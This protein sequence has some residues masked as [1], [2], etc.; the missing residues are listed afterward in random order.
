MGQN[1]FF[2]SILKSFKAQ[3]FFSVCVHIYLTRLKGK[4]KLSFCFSFFF[5]IDISIN[6]KGRF[7]FLLYCQNILIVFYFIGQSYCKVSS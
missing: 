7:S 1:E 5:G 4:K 2:F 6:S 3:T